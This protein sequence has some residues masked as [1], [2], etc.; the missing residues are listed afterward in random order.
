MGIVSELKMLLGTSGRGR[1]WFEQATIHDIRY[2]Y[3]YIY[4]R[5][6]EIYPMRHGQRGRYGLR[7]MR[8]LDEKHRNC[9]Q[10]R[11]LLL[12]NLRRQDEFDKESRSAT[13]LYGIWTRM[14]TCLLS[15]IFISRS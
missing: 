7:L 14:P 8:A 11:G 12:V 10:Q 2:I 1:P 5:C 15:G 13:I 6:D 9:S 4:N 3:I